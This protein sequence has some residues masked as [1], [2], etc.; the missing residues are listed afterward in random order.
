[1]SSL[2][3]L[4][5]AFIYTFLLMSI[6][7]T[8][9]VKILHSC[10]SCSGEERYHSFKDVVLVLFLNYPCGHLSALS[11]TCRMGLGGKGILNIFVIYVWKIYLLLSKIKLDSFRRLYDYVDVRLYD[12]FSQKRK[13]NIFIF[14][15]FV[16]LVLNNNLPWPRIILTF[17][18]ITYWNVLIFQIF[19]P[20]V[21]VLISSSP[22]LH[23]PEGWKHPWTLLLSFSSFVLVH[24]RH[25][26]YSRKPNTQKLHMS[27]RL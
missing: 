7:R 8:E 2:R 16:K 18:Q 23:K 4:K 1:M 5:S 12:R 21:F 19:F 3:F 11:N 17:L 13:G 26:G 27:G 20:S 6:K 25:W 9:I 24:S 15:S 10:V 22:Q 14:I